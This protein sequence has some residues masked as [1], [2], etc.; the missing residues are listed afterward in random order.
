MGDDQT[1]W[2][3]AALLAE[4]VRLNP[5]NPGAEPRDKVLIP[6]HLLRRTTRE[7]LAAV[8]AEVN[9]LRP[10]TGAAEPASVLAVRMGAGGHPGLLDHIQRAGPFMVGGTHRVVHLLDFGAQSLVFLGED[11]NRSP[12][13]IKVP[14]VDYTDLARLDVDRLQRRRQGLLHEAEMLRTFAGTAFPRFIAEHIGQN[15]LF[16]PGLPSFLRDNERFLVLER[17]EG[18]RV[19]TYGRVLHRQGRPCCARRLAAQFGVAFLDL[20]ATIIE[21]LGANAAYTDVKPE[22]ALLHKSTV[23][24]VDASSIAYDSPSRGGIA[25]SELYLD[26]LDRKRWVRGELLPD[27]GFT[28]RCVARCMRV[29]CSNAPLFV[30]EQSPPWSGPE[31][32]LGATVD[33]LVAYDTPDLRAAADTLRLALSQLQ[34]VHGRGPLSVEATEG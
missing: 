21:R 14:F 30:G 16:P 28:I 15:P 26:P 22:N 25:V 7:Q 4:I 3:D 8:L 10:S 5:H 23:R 2:I 24:V 27:A 6:E 19:D 33:G 9:R 11:M 29:L 31:D 12:V 32:G 13:A 20:A 1:K 17:I 34:C 18:Q